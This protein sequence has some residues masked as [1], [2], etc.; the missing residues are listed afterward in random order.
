MRIRPINP[1]VSI[2]VIT[3]NSSR[4][5]LETLESAKN[6]T[7]QNIELIVTDDNSSDD[8]VYV[9]RKWIDENKTRFVRAE[10]IT[11]IS[12]TGIPANINRGLKRVNGTW[13]KCIAGD[14]LLA[15]D[16]LTGLINYILTQ[17][18]DIRILSSNIV[19]FSGNFIGKGDLKKNPNTWFCSRDS[20][21]KDQYE[22]LL[23]Y[24]RVFA[25]SVIIRADLLKSLNV[26]KK[27]ISCWKIGQCG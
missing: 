25:S 11:A 26:L 21:A 18:E 20:S 6:Q 8:T 12:N 19:S 15:K 4:F 27:D 7:Y 9:C 13:I 14:D 17:Q 1:L 2:I 5:V 22:M 3:Y 10:L 23:R 24:N 16:C